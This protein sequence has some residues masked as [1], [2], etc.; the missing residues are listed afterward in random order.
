M[1]GAL[2]GNRGVVSTCSYEARVFGIRSAM[3]I[4]EA[5]S[6]CPD[7]IFLKPNMRSY[8]EASDKVMAILDSLSPVVEQVSVDEAYLDISGLE[9]LYGSPEAIGRKI[10]EAVWQETQLSCSVGVGSNRLIAKLASEYNKPDGLT[11]VLADQIAAFLDPMPVANLRGVGPKTLKTVQR[12]GIRTVRQLRDYTLESLQHYFGEKMGGGLYR[13]AR[14]EAS[15]YVGVRGERS[16]ISKETTFGVDTNDLRKLR[17]TLRQ[18]TAEVGRTLR[19]EGLKGQVVSIKVR[20]PGFETHT[21]QR[22]LALAEDRDAVLFTVAWELFVTSAQIGR[23]IRLIGMGVSDWGDSSGTTLDLFDSPHS[24]DRDHRLY[25]M[26]DEATDRFGKGK[27]SMGIP[28][29]KPK[30]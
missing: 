6:R 18:L 3:P 4:A 19:S 29:K 2:P 12:L 14:G 23:P 11:V 30:P 20:L 17:T 22:R 21:R 10:K 13:Q 26:M 5:Y 27:L 8:S 16:S 7:A 1:V 15:D 9:R 24:S 25:N 28:D